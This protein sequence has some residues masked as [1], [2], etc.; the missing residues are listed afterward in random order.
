MDSPSAHKPRPADYRSFWQ[1]GYEGA[2]H[3][4]GSGHSLEILAD[5]RHLDYAADD[6]R[7]LAPLDIRTVR[8]S[9]GWRS[10]EK[11]GRFDFF[12]VVHRAVS[13]EKQKI[14][15]LW[16]CMHYGIPPDLDLFTDRFTERFVL[17]CSALARCLVPYCEGDFA[18][19]FTPINE[20]SFLTWAACHTGLMHPHTGDAGHRA[21]ELKKHLVQASLLG[22]EAIRAF[23][24]HARFLHVDPI[25]HTVAP[26][27][28][29]EL[30]DA[31]ARECGYQYQAW[32]MLAG[33]IEPQ[34]GGSPGALDLVGVNYYP[35]NQ[36]EIETGKVLPWHLKDPRRRSFVD[37]LADVSTRYARPVT[38]AETSH[39]GAGKARWLREITR[40]IR[41]AQDAGIPVEGIC[42]YPALD[43]PDWERPS[44][45][46]DSGLWSVDGADPQRRRSIDYP[47]ADALRSSQQH[48]QRSTAPSS[49]EKTMKTLVVL[50][51]LR[52]DFV[53]QRPQHILSRLARTRKILFVEEPMYA[54]SDPV[55]EILEPAANVRVLRPHL[56]GQ[57]MGYSDEQ[58]PQIS[59][60]LRD[61]LSA[62]G[63]EN[64]SVWFYT[65]MAL[66]LLDGLSP[67]A[68]VY[69][70]MDELSA[71]DG[72][73]PQLLAREATL[74]KIASLVFTGGPSLYEVKRH[75]HDN[76]HCFP[77][78]VDLAHFEQGA[79]SALAHP[80]IAALPRPRLGFYGV[81]DERLDAH[82][83]AEIARARPSWQLCLVGPIVKIDPAVL[84]QA[85]NI[86][87]FPQQTYAALPMFLAGWDVCLLPF[88]KN[89]STRFISPTKT[90]EYMAA[91]KPVVSTDIADVVKLYGSAVRVASDARTFI[92]ACDAAL[93]E[94]P[95]DMTRRHAAML[96][97]TTSTSWDATAA[98]MDE[99]L[100]L[101][102]VEGLGLAAR[103]YLQSEKIVDMHAVHRRH[104]ADTHS[105]CL[106]LGAGPTG[107]SAALHYGAGCRVLERHST[108]GGWCR[109][110]ED[111]GFQFDYAGH[112]MFSKDPHVLEMYKLLLGDNLHWQDRE[113]W[114]Y[115]KGV[116]TRYPF[117]GSL[118][119]LPAD[120][121]KECLMGAIE[122]RFGASKEISE[123]QAT[124]SSDK[125]VGAPG[126]C[127]A[128]GTAID[129]A[130]AV[131]ATENPRALHS[132]GTGPNDVAEEN[133]EQF[134]YRVWGR[135][136]AKH[137][138]V[139]YNQKLWAT[140]LSEMETSWLGGRVPLPNLEEMIDGA[141]QPSTKPM[142]PNARF[143]YPLRG[144][145]QA[146]MDGF[147]PHIADQLTLDADV[148]SIAP[149]RKI[150]ELRDGRRFSYDH[151]ISTLPLPQ[152]LN[153]IGP[154]APQDV[155][156]AA[157]KLRHVSVRCVN[158][159]VG[160][161]RITDKHWV[162]YPEDT[163]FHRIFMQGNASPHCNPEGG[164]GLTCE[165]TYAPSKPLPAEGSALIEQCIADC[166]RVGIIEA[167]D[168]ILVANE[169]DMPY[170]YVVYDHARKASV[171]LIR[172]W[173]LQRDIHLS[174]RYSEWEYY[175]S[176]HAFIAGKRAAETVLDALHPSARDH[177]E[178]G[179]TS[180]A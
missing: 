109:S 144:G 136:V 103:S 24:P 65:P 106:I 121:L 31:A 150:V 111:K 19:V 179:A 178:K 124:V 29:P 168:P 79:D 45:W 80:G 74:L 153:L 156:D 119:G 12:D 122:A 113:A 139:P 104:E 115:S 39:T 64:Y 50:S 51:H 40:D 48:M 173:L 172:A 38:I 93:K 2:D 20:I 67:E 58:A 148:S 125:H 134:I 100:E 37:M 34:L 86:H 8:E 11:E 116:H 35:N 141:L 160:R 16:T 61:Q 152:L 170:A 82:L 46:H 92:E 88:A 140:P 177:L 105:P 27:G 41:N 60:L 118:Y 84:P 9:A 174:G 7:A 62:D 44:S 59:R 4:N 146:L 72:A 42:L 159:G 157:A 128:D 21:Y 70:C 5:T 26:E 166:I 54:D 169:V 112:I 75:L 98:G 6:Y 180:R 10:I 85:P 163:V 171:D 149:E 96:D 32:D 77:S 94:A 132:V 83:I 175:N 99:L 13:A 15:I 3:V 165:I 145:F 68:I 142:G 63:I 1:V 56:R 25:V 76:I 91:K 23:I 151:L 49:M 138:A 102:E 43:R 155:H 176:D 167:S 57:S 28:R 108:V 69:D 33:R 161:E 114:V 133:F 22:A 89:A 90:L 18:P 30:V 129:G 126:D 81:I 95:A 117:Q 120:V 71:F 78:S 73:P 97:L 137:F 101:S 123:A 158:I 87:Y 36:Y 154:Q 130:S 107:L 127:C 164:F 52:W 47:Y 162:Y 53:F 17:Y 143:G 55:A 147:L 66:P 135:G 14:Q 131:I 110:I